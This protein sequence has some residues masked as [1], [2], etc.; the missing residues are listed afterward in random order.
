MMNEAVKY[1]TIDKLNMFL[2]CYSFWLR[3]HYAA[4][5]FDVLQ[6]TRSI[7]K[8]TLKTHSKPECRI[9]L[10]NHLLHVFW[11]FFF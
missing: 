8:E 2:V 6:R 5:A 1:S 3:Q 4:P 10:R 11:A 9:N 7:P